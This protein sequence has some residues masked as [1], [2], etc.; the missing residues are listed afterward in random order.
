MIS[1]SIHALKSYLSDLVR[2]I[3][4]DRLFTEQCHDSQRPP[5]SANEGLTRKTCSSSRESP[6]YKLIYFATH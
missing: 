3:Y 1:T 2:F 6:I 5:C 4:T